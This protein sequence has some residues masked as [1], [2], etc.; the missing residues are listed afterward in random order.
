MTPDRTCS[1]AD[2]VAI[3]YSRYGSGDPALVLVHGGLANRGFWDSTVAAFAGEHTVVTVDLAGHGDSSA[4]RTTWTVAQF[5]GDVKAAADAE[6]LQRMVVVGNSLGAPVAV[7]AALLMPGRVLGVVAV[8]TFQSFHYQ[9]D[10]DQMKQQAQAF[11][12][13]YTGCVHQM[14]MMLFHA[15]ADPNVMADAERRMQRTP[16][17]AAAAMFQGMA[18]YD[19][20]ASA[21]RLTVPVVAINGDMQPT[22]IEG[23]RAVCPGFDAIIMPHMGHYPMLERPV[24][25]HAHLAAVVARLAMRQ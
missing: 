17:A 18:G 12:A 25:F 22:D 24:E 11:L 1:A 21:R 8:D 6:N 7:E 5:G 16:P 14:V 20:A 10:P 9:L 4:N 19:M 23:G 13:G 15:D 3:A 2:G